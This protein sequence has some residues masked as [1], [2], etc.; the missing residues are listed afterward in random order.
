MAKRPK[1]HNYTAAD[2]ASGGR[3]AA[4]V[5]NDSATAQ[6]FV[7]GIHTGRC[8]TTQPNVRGSARSGGETSPLS[9]VNPGV[10]GEGFCKSG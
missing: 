10:W 7:D 2:G 4:P 6:N 9:D 5:E 1:V 8:G 3:A